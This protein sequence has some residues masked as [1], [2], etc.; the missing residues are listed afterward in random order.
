MQDF[1]DNAN[2]KLQEG[3][4]R[5]NAEMQERVED[6]NQKINSG[7]NEGADR[8][9]QK[10]D[11]TVNSVHDKVN[12][13]VNGVNQVANNKLNSANDQLNDTVDNV[14]QQVND[15]VHSA[16]ENINDTVN[17]PS[18]HMN[19]VSQQINDAVDGVNQQINDSAD[20]VNEHINDV[21]NQVNDKVNGVNDEVNNKQSDIEEQQRKQ[22]EENQRKAQEQQDKV[23]SVV[24]SSQDSVHIRLPESFGEMVD[25]FKAAIER[26]QKTLDAIKNREQ[27]VGNLKD[28]LKNEINEKIDDLKF[29]IRDKLNDMIAEMVGELSVETFDA[30]MNL[31]DDVDDAYEGLDVIEQNAPEEYHDLLKEIKEGLHNSEDKNP[32]IDSNPH[33]PLTPNQWHQTTPQEQIRQVE[34]DYRYSPQTGRVLQTGIEVPTIELASYERPCTG[35]CREYI[36]TDIVGENDIL[37]DIAKESASG[38]RRMAQQQ[39][40]VGFKYLPDGG[41]SPTLLAGESGM[42]VSPEIN[43]LTSTSSDQ[44]PGSTETVGQVLAK[45]AEEYAEEEDDKKEEDDKNNQEEDDKK[46]DKDNQ[47]VNPEDHPAG[48]TTSAAIAFLGSLAAGFAFVMF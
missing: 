7:L 10:I 6:A 41:M 12:D 35:S 8:A 34:V 45:L 25:A 22:D 29:Q 17:G 40:V 27:T 43:G 46:P 47:P 5:A 1:N 4:D 36:C 42:N 33:Q 21:H 48:D 15:H 31:F 28:G 2:D 24:K 30:Q 32:I 18:E 19:G 11:D 13:T 39:T 23:D 16:N 37:V 38:R 44:L 9:N 20:N 3:A 14:N 26:I